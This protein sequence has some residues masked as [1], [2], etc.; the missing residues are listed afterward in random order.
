M[1]S[2]RPFLYTLCHLLFPFTSVL[3][4]FALFFPLFG[5]ITPR[6]RH[7]WAFIAL[8]CD[9]DV[10]SLPMSSF[11]FFG[12]AHADWWIWISSTLI[13]PTQISKTFKSP[14]R[15]P[16]P[17][18]SSAF[19]RPRRVPF[20]SY[21]GSDR[22]GRSTFRDRL[23]DPLCALANSFARTFRS[24]LPP[25]QRFFLFFS[26]ACSIMGKSKVRRHAAMPAHANAPIPSVEGDGAPQ[27]DYGRLWWRGQ[28]GAH[29]PVHVRRLCRG[30]RS[31]ES[32]QLPQ[33]G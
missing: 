7:S 29:A 17:W 23:F 5:L 2:I 22:R 12:T 16:F 32:R 24:L 31:H 10:S 9:H 21:N 19:Q 11:A 1:R 3:F 15:F 4:V 25:A 33:E 6:L 14:A 13:G 26:F 20:V 18:K 8:Y 28:V 30:L 27:G